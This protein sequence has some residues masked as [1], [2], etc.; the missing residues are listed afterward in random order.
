M[1]KLMIPLAFMAMAIA[2]SCTKEKENCK[3]Y[4]SLGNGWYDHPPTQQEKE[5]LEQ[6]CG[7][8]VT[9]TKQCS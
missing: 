3:W 2:F 6:Q 1:K 8:T 4:D 5:E 7:C 9:F